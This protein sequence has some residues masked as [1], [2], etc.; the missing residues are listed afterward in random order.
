MYYDKAFYMDAEEEMTGEK[1]REV[2][3]QHKVISTRYQALRDLYVGEHPIL[4]QEP[5][6]ATKPD[7]RLVANFARY[8]VDTFNGYFMGIPV[9]TVSDNQVVSDYIQMVER[10]NDIDDL[11]ADLSKKC[12]IY[13]HAFE[14]LYLDEEAQVG[15][16][17]IAPDECILVR[18]TSIREEPLYGIRYTTN[19]DGETVGTIS[20][21][22]SIKYF[23]IKAGEVQIVDE[24]ENFFHAVPIIE[25]VEN[26]ERVGAFEWVE[27]LINAYNKALS[28]K[29]ND[30]DYFADAYMKILGAKLDEKVL[31]QIRDY[32]IINLEKTSGDGQLVVDFMQKPNADTTQEN[33]LERI[34]KLIFQLSMVPNINDEKFGTASGIALQYKLQSMSNLANTKERKFVKGFNRRYDLIA[35]LPNSKI[36]PDDLVG[37]EYKF[38][39]N[40]PANVRDEAETAR[41]LQGIVSDETILENLS[42]V[43]DVKKELERIKDEEQLTPMIEM[44]NHGTVMEDEEATD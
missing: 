29:A 4:T 27:Y 39:R 21:S 28:E 23:V 22:Q 24:K 35:Q 17:Q 40:I 5:K 36:R 3:K 38:T 9:K 25:Y 42:I 26:E 33:L 44:H 7:N 2:I 14:L 16:T 11:N 15:I 41:S 34:E 19:A 43:G 20:D 13:G 18:S 37:I 12:D 6:P 30:V 8:I 31:A 1:I 10:Y 32:R